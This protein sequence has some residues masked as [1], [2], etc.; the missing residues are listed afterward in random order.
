MLAEAFRAVD[1]VI[2]ASFLG[3]RK[4]GRRSKLTDWVKFEDPEVDPGR[5]RK[6]GSGA[7]GRGRVM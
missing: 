6:A 1:N 2:C 3:G 5:V 7:R 4:G